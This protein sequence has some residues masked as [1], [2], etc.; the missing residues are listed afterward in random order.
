MKK[1]LAFLLVVA[2]LCSFAACAGDP[3][4]SSSNEPSTNAPS[5]NPGT[6]APVEPTEP[7]DPTEPTGPVGPVVTVFPAADTA[8]YYGMV[9]ANKDNTVYYLAG[10]MAQTYYLDTTTDAAASLKIYLE[11]TEGGYYLYCL[12]GTTKTYINM[13]V[14]GT[15]VNANYQATASTVYTYDNANEI[16]VAQVNGEPYTLGTRNDG[17][18]TTVGPVAVSQKGFWCK[19]YTDDTLPAG[20]E[21]P[22]MPEYNTTLTIAQLLALPVA[23][24]ETTSGRFY[25]RATIQS[26]TDARYGAMIITDSTGSI[27]IYNSASADGK[28]GYADMADQPLKGDEVLLHVNVKNFKDSFEINSAWIQEVKHNTIDETA[29]TQM[30]I[31]EA[32][33]QEIGT[34]VKVEGV[35]AAITNATGFIPDGV[36]LVDNTG[37]I[38]IY[39]RDLAGRVSVGNKI[40]L[41]GTKAMWINDSETS[42]A[43]KYHY[44]GSNQIDKAWLLSNDNGEHDFDKTWIQESTVKEIVDTP[45]TTDIST[46]IYKVNALVKEKPGNGFTNFYFYDLDGTTGSYTYTKCNGNDFAWLR[47]YEGKVCTVYLMAINAK[48]EPSGCFWRFLPIAVKD[49]NFDISSVNI[50]EFVVKYFGVDQFDSKYTGN[51]A[52]ELMT[53]VSSELLAIKDAKLSYK[54]SDESVISVADNKLVCL[55]NGKVTITITCEYNGKTYSQNVEVEYA[56]AKEMPS[57]SVKDAVAAAV[58]DEVVVKGI[59]GPSLVNRKG[60]YLMSDE[61]MIAIIT[62]DATMAG[63]QIGNT[64]ILRGTRAVMNKYLAEGG[65]PAGSN[66][67]GQSYIK[68]AVVEWNGYGEASWD[69]S[70]Y[71]KDKTAGQLNDLDALVDYTTN[72][73]VITGKVLIQGYNY[74]I[75]GADGEFSLYASGAAQYAWLAAYNG[76]EVTVSVACCNWN[77]KKFYKGSVLSIITDSGEIYNEL[78]FSK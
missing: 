51:P 43:A 12:E 54:S 23:D 64:V 72:V 2:M 77:D 73:Y 62:D 22:D 38:L 3:A 29:Y 61:G 27:S 34:L 15:H 49:E 60:F 39:D 47:E 50:P 48:S 78:N 74:K 41:A 68:D 26:V 70:W 19:L 44:A 16:L 7:T 17:T 66:H 75:I 20:P 65:D 24:G 69:T 14:N 18:Y 11:T 21:K 46:V 25:V 33:K 32:R 30:T 56:E 57:I 9:Q 5:T 71:I 10:G 35:V 55:K 45:I 37:S 58:G 1:I 28:T 67:F 4:P 31:D 42:N 36:I 59:V 76:Q 52:S 40:T 63:L 53:T 6:T 8:Y 13:T